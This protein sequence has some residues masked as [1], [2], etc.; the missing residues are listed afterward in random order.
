MAVALHDGRDRLSLQLRAAGLGRRD[1]V[2]VHAAGGRMPESSAVALI[3]AMSLC[4]G[5][6]GTIV[7]PG[8]SSDALMPPELS[9]HD[10]AAR[11]AAETQIAGF[12]P[13]RSPADLAGTLGEA[14]RGLPG[15]ERSSHPIFSL[16]ARGPKAEHITERHPRD[17]A[18]GID[19]PMG[20]L[21]ALPRVKVVR[22][23]GA[24]WLDCPVMVTA[25]SMAR[26]RRLAVVRF[27]DRATGRW[28]HARDIAVDREGI[29]E[30]VGTAMSRARF[31]KRGLLGRTIVE[32][33][34]LDEMLGFAAPRIA[35]LVA[36]FG[37][38][39]SAGGAAG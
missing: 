4:I 28:I 27:K 38:A 17:W 12:D 3:E 26:H 31:V 23:G 1:N 25:E 21:A 10:A 35:Q 9:R 7:V 29:Y 6:S 24:P 33:A 32:I 16:L 22:I 2:I 5:R 37:N 13:D 39:R 34:P 20:R 36:G 19:G 14:F 18:L 15:V 11:A 8:F 30:C